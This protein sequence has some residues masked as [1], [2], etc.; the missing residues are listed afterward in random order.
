MAL[1]M[2]TGTGRDYDARLGIRPT[3]ASR[4]AGTG[5]WAAREP[6]RLRVCW[7]AGLVG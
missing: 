6:A 7:Q 4:G 5:S 3:Y 2:F 1:G